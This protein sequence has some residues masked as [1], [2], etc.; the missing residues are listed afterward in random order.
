MN[1]FLGLALVIGVPLTITANAHAQSTYY[2]VGTATPVYGLPTVVGQPYGGFGL[3]YTPA[4]PPGGMVMDQYGMLHPVSYGAPAPGV[5]VQTQPSVATR[6]Y[7]SR[8]GMAQPRYV[9]PTGSLGASAGNGVMLYP[10]GSR[11]AGYGS[12]YSVG[13]YGVVD[14]RMMWKW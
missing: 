7:G 8:R 2:D 12:G 11:Y 5:I 14:H 4:V 1:R 9:L 13:P 6:R 10:V 3:Q